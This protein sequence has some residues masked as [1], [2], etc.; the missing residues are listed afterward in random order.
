MVQWDRTGGANQTWRA[1]S[2]GGDVYKIESC[3]AHGQYLAVKDS[4]Y[5]NG[6]KI[7]INSQGPSIQWRIEGSKP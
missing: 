4:D 1:V 7:E 6:G 5:E 3:H 2:M